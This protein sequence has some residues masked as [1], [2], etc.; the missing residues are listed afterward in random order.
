[1]RRFCGERKGEGEKGRRGEG[2]PISLCFSTRQDSRL[3]VSSAHRFTRSP[4]HPFTPLSALR[5]P[6]SALRRGLTLLEVILALAI[7]AGAV[8]AIGEL[9]RTGLLSATDARD[10]TRA[11]L[12][13]ETLMSQVV[14][15]AMAT[16]SV[17]SSPVENDPNYLY[18]MV[19]EEVPAD[20]AG[21]IKISITVGRN[22]TSPK[23]PVQFTLVRWMVDPQMEAD[24]A[25]Q[26]QANAQANAT[27]QSQSQQNSSSSSSSSNG[28]SNSTGG[29]Q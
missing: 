18:S 23:K 1:M 5:T 10:Y 21:L 26:A 24:L 12:Y 3:M 22:Q 7:L 17:T 16:G 25:A 13:A 11:E 8:A 2:L 9:V 27:A 14:S 28:A 29:Q 6:D 20:Q 4:L 19:T 15:G